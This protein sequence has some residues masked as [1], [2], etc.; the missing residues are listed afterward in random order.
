MRIVQGAKKGELIF[1]ITI[2]GSLANSDKMECKKKLN[3]LKEVFRIFHVGKD[4]QKMQQKKKCEKLK[5]KLD[6]ED[7]GSTYNCVYL[8][9]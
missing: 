7:Y 3:E 6:F 8:V 9:E 1:K 5:N 4:V 2:P